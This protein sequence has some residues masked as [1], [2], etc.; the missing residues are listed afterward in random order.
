MTRISVEVLAEDWQE[1][2]A[3]LI[4][5]LRRPDFENSVLRHYR[6]GPGYST[7]TSRASGSG[8]QPK[9][10]LERILAGYPLAPADP[11]LSVTGQALRALAGRTLRPNRVVLGVGGNVPR[12]EVEAALNKLSEGWDST[13][14]RGTSTPDGPSI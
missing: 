10:E 14:P 7:R 8:F 4:D 11:G 13:D 2:L 1:G 6:T 3:V 12:A 5:V 9:V